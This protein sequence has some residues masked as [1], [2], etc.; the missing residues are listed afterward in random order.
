MYKSGLKTGGKHA[1]S[2]ALEINRSKIIQKLSKR[3]CL[4]ASFFK[5]D[6]LLNL[7]I[8]GYAKRWPK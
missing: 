5:Q 4:I 7:I 1:I 3:D 2:S 8:L 6:H